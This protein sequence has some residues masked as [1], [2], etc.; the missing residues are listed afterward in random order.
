MFNLIDIPTKR[1]G[2]IFVFYR[3]FSISV[4]QDLMITPTGTTHT[5]PLTGSILFTCSVT[6]LSSPEINP[7]LKWFDRN[8]NEIT[9]RTGRYATRLFSLLRGICAYYLLNA[10][11]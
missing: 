5:R 1:D 2:C 3:V 4:A 7:N 9:Q 6:G 10:L 11:T 8:S